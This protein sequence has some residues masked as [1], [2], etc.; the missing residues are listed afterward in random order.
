MNLC[1]MLNVLDK[2]LLTNMISMLIIISLKSVTRLKA[3]TKMVFILVFVVGN[4]E[5]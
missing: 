1:S 4:K 3:K 2:N 5:L